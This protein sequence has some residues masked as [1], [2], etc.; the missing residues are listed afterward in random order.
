MI[1]V[2][3]S[4][5]TSATAFRSE[6]FPE[7][8]RDNLRTLQVNLGYRCNQSCAHCHVNAG[9][10]R[11]EMMDPQTMALIPKVLDQYQLECLDLTGG[12]PELHPGFKDLVIQASCLGVEVI[13]RCNLT[14]LTEPG[15]DDLAAFLAKHR[16]TVVA[17]LPCYEAENV[18]QQRGKGVFER[19]LIGL[20]QLNQLG[21]GQND[22]QLI[23]NLIFN[24][25]GP[26]LPPP[27][28]QL[29]EAYRKELKQ[30]YD[31]EF[32]RLFSIAN[33]PIQR[34][35]TQLTM[36]GQRESYQQLLEG[37]HNPDNLKTVMC[38]SLISVNWQGQLF[39]CD[40]NQ[41]LSL[42]LKGPVQHLRDLL[43]VEIQWPGQPITVGP[44]CFGCTAGNGS[45]CGGALQSE[46]EIG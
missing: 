1:S 30:R 27:Q 26:Q 5:E 22:E 39:D 4:H 33:M 46:G 6:V 7:L 15:Q 20:R 24:P 44:H 8:H 41:Q 23:L 2:L 42:H 28:A 3:P 16:V 18:D 13:D 34:F 10:T 14:I 9:P 43:D 21:Y 40:F 17:S 19:S 32:T 45:S 35:A 36:S 31:I 25:Q 11:L 37:A 12:A 38:R 29:E